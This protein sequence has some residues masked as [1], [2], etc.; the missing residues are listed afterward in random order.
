MPKRFYLPVTDPETGKVFLFAFEAGKSGP[1]HIQV[2]HGVAPEEAI[3][4]YIRGT[5]AWN[6]L[7]KRNETQTS[8]HMLYWAEHASGAILV[9]SCFP[10]GAR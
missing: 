6:S 8:R 9:I 7:N 3:A 10:I 1:F 4:T 5:T 2:R